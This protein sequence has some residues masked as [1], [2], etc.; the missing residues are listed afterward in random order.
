MGTQFTEIALRGLKAIAVALNLP[1]EQINY[2]ALLDAIFKNLTSRERAVL[3]CCFGFEKDGMPNTIS[4]TAKKLNFNTKKEV[5]SLLKEALKTLDKQKHTFYNPQ[6]ISD[7]S[8]SNELMEMWDLNLMS[9]KA[10]CKADKHSLEELKNMTLKEL[11]ALPDLRIE[12]LQNIVMAVKKYSDAKFILEINL[13]H[14]E[15]SEDIPL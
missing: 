15:V 5:I 6:R 4:E 11:L 2:D 8:T 12:D 3:V 14:L 9:Y 1:I 10:L 7:I 13:R